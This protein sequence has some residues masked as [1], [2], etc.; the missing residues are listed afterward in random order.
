MPKFKGIDYDF[1]GEW[2]KM[3]IPAL[4][5]A[6]LELLQDDLAGFSGEL[7]KKNISTAIMA[8]HLALKRNYPDI[9]REQVAEMVDLS[10]MKDVM[11]AV[12]NV[13][14][15]KAKEPIAEDQPPGESIGDISTPTS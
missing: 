14:G 11:L 10:N 15:L 3:T 1:G 13:S 4:N 7:D 2:G 5:L 6:A 12:M 8:V 9:S